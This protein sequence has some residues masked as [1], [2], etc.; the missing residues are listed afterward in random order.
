M[1]MAESPP[2]PPVLTGTIVATSRDTTGFPTLPAPTAAGA[3]ALAA[4]QAL[5][6]QAA[7][8]ATR[9]G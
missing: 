3:T 1:L 7:A 5:A 4:A 9:S 6:R 2:D 8:P